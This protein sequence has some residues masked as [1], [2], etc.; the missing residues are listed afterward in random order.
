MR[1]RHG[2]A[3]VSSELS[4]DG[5]LLATADGCSVVVWELASG[6]RLHYLLGDAHYFFAYP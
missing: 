6:R 4:P 5:K 3:I 2:A 1:W